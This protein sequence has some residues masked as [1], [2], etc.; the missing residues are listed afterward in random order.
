MSPEQYSQKMRDH[1]RV[2]AE[3]Q[4]VNRPPAEIPIRSDRELLHE[5]QVHQIE[6]EVQN[7]A[8][9]QAQQALEESRDRFVDLY[10]FAPVGY[11]TL[12]AEGLITEVNLT[13]VTL[14]GVERNKLLNRSLRM[15]VVA[16]DQDRWVRHFMGAIKQQE[17]CSIE[18]SIQSG[19]GTV[20]PAQLDCVSAITATVRIS[21]TDISDRKKIEEELQRHREHL[22]NLVAERTAELATAK[23]FAEAAN[24]AKSAF[25]ANMS[26]ELRTPMNG[27]MGMTALAQRR[28][29]DPKQIDQLNKVAVSSQYLLSIINDILDISKIEAERLTI[30]RIPFK[31]EDLLHS[32]HSLIGSKAE[33]KGLKLVTHLPPALAVHLFRGDPLHLTQILLNL[34]NNAIKFTATGTIT[35]TMTQMEEIDPHKALDLGGVLLRFEVCDTGIGIAHEDQLRLF[36]AF[37]Q[38]DSSTTRQFGG[39][40]LGLTISKRLAYLMGGALGVESQVGVGSTFWFTAR[41]EHAADMEAAVRAHDLATDEVIQQLKSHYLHSQILLVEDEPINREVIIFELEEIGFKID[42][43]EDGEQA[44]ESARQTDYDLILMDVRMPKM[45]GLEATQAIRALPGRVSAVPILAITAN[46]FVEDRQSCLDAGMNDHMSKPVVPELLYAMVLKWLK[47]R[48]L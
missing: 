13:A 37:E 11:L 47:V 32:L 30:E 34:V 16:A 29:T 5:L 43:A 40:G 4:L 10:E 35:L 27:I 6:L 42:W 28:A 38:L 39:T 36:N 2:V 9:R 31:L 19:D 1:L 23:E 3:E 15:R 25:L 14:L 45:G 24:R 8:L 44:V 21:L 26:H 7:E 17:K 12:S 18:L 22:E 48:P 46:V 41:V 20:F 33:D